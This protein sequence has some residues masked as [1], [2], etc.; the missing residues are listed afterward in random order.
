MHSVANLKYLVIEH[1]VLLTH[2][3]GF[4]AG[5]DGAGGS[6]SVRCFDQQIWYIIQTKAVVS[7]KFELMLPFSVLSRYSCA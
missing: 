4:Y 1:M 3:F 5:N 6:E 7:H 2:K